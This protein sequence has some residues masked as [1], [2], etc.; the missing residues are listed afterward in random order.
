MPLLTSIRDGVREVNRRYARP[1]IETTRF[2]RVCLV[3]LRVYLMLM[4][5]LMVYALVRTAAA[6][7]DAVE[8]AAPPAA[9]QPAVPAHP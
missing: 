7:R 5:A 1:E 3:G 8:P 9:S 6:G 2:T 4:V